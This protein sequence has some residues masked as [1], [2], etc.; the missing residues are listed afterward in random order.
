MKVKVVT[1]FGGSS[2][3]FEKKTKSIEELIIYSEK[4]VRFKDIE[5]YAK[6]ASLA[7]MK[8]KIELFIFHGVRQYGHIAVDVFG[9][10]PKARK[11]CKFL[12]DIF[13]EIFRRYLP[14]EQVDLANLCKWNEKLKIFEFTDYLEKIVQISESGGIPISFG[15]IV[16]K[17]PKGY[18][19]ISGDDVFL[20]TGLMLK[21]KEGVMYIDVPVCD[22]NPKKYKDAR[23]LKVLNSY[24]NIN[25]DVE[26][27][28]K[29][30]GLIGKL[31]KVEILALNGVKCQI[32]N[33]IKKGNVYKSLLGKNV[34]TLIQ[35]KL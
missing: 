24:K 10:S 12:S 35:P 21:V 1:K 19:I 4:F 11:Y 30:G 9:V 18:A 2:I 20:Y 14:I 28:D 6:E 5:R 29:T 16:N 17:I 27:F 31:K 26:S 34:G 22:K 3:T 32:V 13:V 15:T 25:I 33:A 23:P 7:F 8:R